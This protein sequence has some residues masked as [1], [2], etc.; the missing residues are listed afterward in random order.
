MTIVVTLILLVAPNQ[1]SRWKYFFK[2]PLG[3]IPG[4]FGVH[5]RA[6]VRSGEF[7]LASFFVVSVSIV[8][9][10]MPESYPPYWLG[11]IS[12]QAVYAVPT[13]K[14]IRKIY[15][16]RLSPFQSYLYLIAPYLL[17]EIVISIPVLTISVIK[18]LSFTEVE[19]TLIICIVALI[20]ALAISIFFPSE[21]YNPFSVLIGVVTALGLVFLITFNT[22]IWQI[23]EHLMIPLWIVISVFCAFYSVM[24]ISSTQ[25][26]EY[27]ADI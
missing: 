4:L 6:T 20:A 14:G 9:L 16:Y 24:G 5:L 18:G 11:I 8:V 12:L 13:S 19:K 25:K 17:V 7:L 27:Y 3:N 22:L 26:K 10:W 2:I 23:P 1:H 15:R 21:K